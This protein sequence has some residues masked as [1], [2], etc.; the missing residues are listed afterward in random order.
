MTEGWDDHGMKML[1]RIIDESDG[2]EVHMVKDPIEAG[3]P[4][5][6]LKVGKVK[7]RQDVGEILVR[8]G[9][10]KWDSCQARYDDDD[11]TL[12][13]KI[14]IKQEVNTSESNTEFDEANQCKDVPGESSS[15]AQPTMFFN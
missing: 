15:E 9:F 10:V 1:H 2:V 7:S 3:V 11:E 5:V 6:E 12:L 13:V 8:N 14:E 4:E